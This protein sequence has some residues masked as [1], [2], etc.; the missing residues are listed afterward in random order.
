MSHSSVQLGVCPVW[1]AS[2]DAEPERKGE[3][4]W[5]MAPY[6]FHVFPTDVGGHIFHDDVESNQLQFMAS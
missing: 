6:N 2:S 5:R 4:V 3:D 1:R